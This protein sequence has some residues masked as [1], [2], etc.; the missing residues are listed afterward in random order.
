MI[1][2]R[3]PEY[4]L[5]IVQH[6]CCDDCNKLKVRFADVFN[7]S[8][9][10][11]GEDSKHWRV[12][13]LAASS[14]VQHATQYGTSEDTSKMPGLK[15]QADDTVVFSVQDTTLITELMGRLK[16]MLINHN[17]NEQIRSQ[18][19]GLIEQW[20]HHSLVET[21]ASSSLTA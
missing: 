7:A 1:T 3:I 21:A 16:W 4:V 14:E 19:A 8:G 6:T 15:L 10:S 2:K 11:R 20:S 9:I 17:T 5:T 12:Q 13:L 18:L